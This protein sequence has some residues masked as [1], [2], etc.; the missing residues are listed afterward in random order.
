MRN[1]PL[2]P[3]G[4][5]LA[6]LTTMFW[7]IGVAAYARNCPI[8]QGNCYALLFVAEVATLPILFGTLV[9]GSYLADREKRTRR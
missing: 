6:A 3:L 8:D 1:F 7:L 4:G 9:F 5:F 2:H